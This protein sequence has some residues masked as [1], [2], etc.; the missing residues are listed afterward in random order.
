MYNIAQGN[1]PQM[2]TREQ[3]SDGGLDFL[4]RCFERDPAKRI[5]A[6][7][8]LCHDWILQLRSQLSLEPGTPQTPALESST[9]PG[10]GVS[11]QNTSS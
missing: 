5:S 4:K 7:E 11:R 3:L 1:P 6:T 2:P 9:G 8:L 10:W